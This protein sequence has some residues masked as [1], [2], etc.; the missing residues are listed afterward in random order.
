VGWRDYLELALG[1]S[2]AF[3]D[4][5]ICIRDT[6]DRERFF[7]S[8]LQAGRYCEQLV[9]DVLDVAADTQE[10][11]L[12]F[13][14]LRLIEQGQV[15]EG[16]LPYLQPSPPL[17]P[18]LMAVLPTYLDR[19]GLLC[20]HHRGY[21]VYHNPYIQAERDEFGRVPVEPQTYETL[22]R[23]IL[24]NTPTELVCSLTELAERRARQYHEFCHWWRGRAFKRCLT[25]LFESRVPL[26]VT[27]S[28]LQFIRSQR[29]ALRVPAP[30]DALTGNKTHYGLALIG[31]A[32]VVTWFR[33]KTAQSDF[34]RWV[35]NLRALTRL[36]P[37]EADSASSL[38]SGETPTLD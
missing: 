35:T 4:I 24:V 6:P 16:L 7:Q 12:G 30:G 28:F 38:L 29:K 23:E 17:I 8:R 37:T 20:T 11:V 15:A 31:T 25:V 18:G 26:A 36:D 27:V 32:G 19:T 21:F 22:L 5:G 33:F 3:L 10:G 14:P 13:L 1:K 34:E 2:N 9:D